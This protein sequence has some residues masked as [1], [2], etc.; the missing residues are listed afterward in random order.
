MAKGAGPSADA[1]LSREE[2]EKFQKLT[3]RNS[4]AGQSLSGLISQEKI[5]EGLKPAA[6]AD[7]EDILDEFSLKM[8]EK[9]LAEQQLKLQQQ[10]LTNIER[11]IQ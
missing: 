7:Q 8:Q 3:R 4:I 1:T 10:T 9:Q 2:G 6:A 5:A 11:R